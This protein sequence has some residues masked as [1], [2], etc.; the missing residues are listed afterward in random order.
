MD[1]KKYEII[2]DVCIVKKRKHIEL[3]KLCDDCIEKSK[4]YNELKYI[5]WKQKFYYHIKEHNIKMLSNEEMNNIYGL[6]KDR[7]ETMNNL[8]IKHN[9]LERKYNNMIYISYGI[10]IICLTG[11]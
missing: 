11:I 5:D 7:D 4:C 2:C 3:P 9:K 10:N 6:L 8:Y 1:N